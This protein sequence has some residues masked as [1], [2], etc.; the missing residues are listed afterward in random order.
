MQTGSD[1]LQSPVSKHL[2]LALPISSNPSSQLYETTIPNAVPLKLAV[3]LTNLPGSP[4]PTQIHIV[5]YY[6]SII[7]TVTGWIVSVQV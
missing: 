2:R 4:H 3:P 5:T 6:A 7:N 1:P